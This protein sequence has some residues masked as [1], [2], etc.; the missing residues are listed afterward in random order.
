M[1]C[2]KCG[3]EA[4]EGSAFCGG[5]GTRLGAHPTPPPLPPAYS[6]PPPAPARSS[7]SGATVA[8]VVVVVGFGLVMFLG[9]IAA[10]AIP[11]LL[12]AVQRGKQKRSMADLRAI[13][14]AC[15]AFAVDNNA[16]PDVTSVSELAK[17]LEPKYIRQLP[18]S[19]GWQHEFRYKPMSPKDDGPQEYV[20]VSAGKD[21]V[22]EHDDLEGYTKVE[23]ES[24]NNDIV[25]SN[26]EFIQYPGAIRR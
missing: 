9:I 7:S 3:K 6:A 25:F 10:I 22:I 20:I 5:C 11:N 2:S 4:Q 14:T 12:N 26:G 19:D 21:G 8:I 15:E 23:T 18:Q 1:F 24:F 17:I 13:G 16:Y